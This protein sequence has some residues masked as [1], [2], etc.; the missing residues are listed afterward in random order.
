MVS[1]T[2][3]VPK[4]IVIKDEGGSRAAALKGL[5]TY[6]FTHM[7]NFLL[8]LLLLPLAS[9]LLAEIWIS[10]LRF[11]PQVWDLCL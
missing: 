8:L 4:L 2:H 1:G 10:R 9:S 11:G 3:T 5:M 6:T 7:G